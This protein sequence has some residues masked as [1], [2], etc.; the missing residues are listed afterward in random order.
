MLDNHRTK[1]IVAPGASSPFYA[2]MIEKM[3]FDA[4]YMSGGATA[5]TFSGLPDIGLISF[6]EVLQNARYIANS[7]AIPL[8]ADADTGYGNAVN[9]IRTTTEFIQ[10]GVS[11]L[12]LE[13]QVFP[14][15]C[16][17]M[18]G[19][20]VI[21]IDEAVGK[22]RAADSVRRNREP[23]FVLI[24]RTD[25]R[26]AVG[27]GF[28][29]VIERLNA[30]AKAGADVCFADGL[31]T[32]REVEIVVK[33]V[34]APILYFPSAMGPKLSVERCLE[35]G[36]AMVVYPNSCL[37]P[38]ASSAWDYFQELKKRDTEAEVE[39]DKRLRGHPLGSL[40]NLFDLAGLSEYQRYE[41]E[42]LPREEEILRYKEDKSFGI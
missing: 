10:A 21:P 31:V 40:R 12:H 13:D 5:L 35:L 9:V 2:K 41:E 26:N 25:V 32:E 1:T 23:N 15:R 14:K 7:V 42:Y 20:L 8:I 22:I 17:Q 16:G 6:G 18:K 34:Q 19:K 36:I 39:L 28:D 3:G 38:M 37:Q 11:A 24:A 30:F 33:K 27:G 4:V 29:H